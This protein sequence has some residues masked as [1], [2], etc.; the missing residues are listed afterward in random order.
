MPQ[1]KNDYLQHYPVEWPVFSTR[2]YKK[3]DKG[4]WNPIYRRR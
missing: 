2:Y 4:W 1:T 3:D